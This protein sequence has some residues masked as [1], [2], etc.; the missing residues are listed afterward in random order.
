MTA[1]QYEMCPDKQNTQDHRQHSYE[2]R[3]V[4]QWPSEKPFPGWLSVKAAPDLHSLILEACP[5][6][7][8]LCANNGETLLPH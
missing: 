7:D 2:N 1:D 5:L 4:N 6:P 8:A 3:D